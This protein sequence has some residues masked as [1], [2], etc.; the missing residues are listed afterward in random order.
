[1]RRTSSIC[2]TSVVL[3]ATLIVTLG[4]MS[5]GMVRGQADDTWDILTREF[6]A[7]PLRRKSRP[8]WFWNARPTA[9]ETAGQME[10]L[11]EIGYAG[12]AILPGGGKGNRGPELPFMSPE[13]LKQYKVAADTAKRLGMKM[14]LYDEYWFPSGY[15][16]G[17][18]A[19][20]Y[21]EALS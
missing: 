9:E 19:K 20:R 5:A 15:A 14:C 8:L 2:Q 6:R 17:L 3:L 16:G 18:L 1:M 4:P 10:K 12:V 11:R 21:P 13:Y 7:P